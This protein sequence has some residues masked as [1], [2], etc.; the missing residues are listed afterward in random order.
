MA[1][2]KKTLQQLG[3]SRGDGTIKLTPLWNVAETEH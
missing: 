2:T 1:T 3:H